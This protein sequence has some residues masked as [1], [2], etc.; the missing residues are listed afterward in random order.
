VDD[1]GDVFAAHHARLLRLA[2][3]ITGSRVAA[4]DAV[5][6]AFARTY[7]K[8]RRGRIDDVG[9]YLRRAVVNECHAHFR[10]RRR[11]EPFVHLATVDSA[12]GEVVEHD[13]V[14]TAI[15]SLPVRQRTVLVLRYWDGLSEAETAQTL[16][17]PIG[18]VK[19]NAS[20]AMT[21]LRSL[22]AER[23]DEIEDARGTR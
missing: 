2:G 15:A 20:R 14:W 19:S 22:L 10:R 12:E 5:A 17:I 9:S 21:T 3:L 7:P 16:R 4:E 8:W 6:E 11:R 13:H 23:D 18:T 1:F